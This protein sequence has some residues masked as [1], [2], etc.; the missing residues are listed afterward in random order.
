MNRLA[1]GLAAGAL[2]LT[3]G[4]GAARAQTP[5]PA[6]VRQIVAEHFLAGARDSFTVELD[7]GRVYRLEL[8]GG[9]G[10][11]TVNLMD[12]RRTRAFLNPREDGSWELHPAA[13]DVHLVRATSIAPGDTVRVRILVDVAEI[14]ARRERRTE[15]LGRSLAIGFSAGGGAR[16]GFRLEATPGAEAVGGAMELEAGLW[17]GVPTARFSA[18]LGTA[19]S[20][21]DGGSPALTWFFVEPRV[22]LLDR[23]RTEFGTSLR[24]GVASIR[25]GEKNPSLVAPGAFLAYRLTDTP[26]RRGPR[27]HVGYAFGIVDNVGGKWATSHRTTAGLVW[28]F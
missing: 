16:S 18:L 6:P 20:G 12:R 14:E 10:T 1:P 24:I 3:L 28:I 8:A 11:P 17:A 4:A 7:D 27:V 5:T 2:A 15:R 22:R 26:T 23:A 19:W 13:S 9:S 25:S 21:A